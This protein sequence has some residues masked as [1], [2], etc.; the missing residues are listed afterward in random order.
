MH[1]YVCMKKPLSQTRAYILAN[2]QNNIYTNVITYIP[3]IE[4]HQVNLCLK[5][6]VAVYV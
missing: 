5:A 2:T 4:G 1:W 3:F 6:L